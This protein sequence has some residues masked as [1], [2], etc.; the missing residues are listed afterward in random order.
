MDGPSL[1]DQ[2]YDRDR[3]L[4]QQWENWKKGFPS[5]AGI[6]TRDY[7]YVEYYA[8]D[9]STVVFREYYD[10]VDEPAM[11]ENLLADDSSENDPDVRSPVQQ[12]GSRQTLQGHLLSLIA[13]RHFA[14]FGYGVAVS[15]GPIGRG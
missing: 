7:Q 15:S 14:N 5:W 13:P 9:E 3:V 4:I 1:F 11:L 2:G 8:R 12:A 10:L 6:R